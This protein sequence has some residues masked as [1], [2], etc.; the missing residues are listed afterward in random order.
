[1]EPMHK[2]MHEATKAAGAALEQALNSATCAEE[3]IKIAEMFVVLGS[4]FLRCFFGEDHVRQF[5][6]KGIDDLDHPAVMNVIR[7]SE[8]DTQH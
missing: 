6:Q 7:V 5:L 4:N 3:Q 1:M 8:S 2:D